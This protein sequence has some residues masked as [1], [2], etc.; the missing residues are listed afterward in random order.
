MESIRIWVR[1]GYSPFTWTSEHGRG[2]VDPEELPVSPELKAAMHD[3]EDAFL[4][5]DY[6]PIRGDRIPRDYVLQGWVLARRLAREL[7]PAPAV[8]WSGDLALDAPRP[9]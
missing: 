3:W 2:E 6:N 8:Y 4:H 5:L 9:Q 1:W 7:G